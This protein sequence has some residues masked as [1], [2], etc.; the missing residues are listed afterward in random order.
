MA[1]VVIIVKKVVFILNAAKTVPYSTV[2][3]FVSILVGIVI[4]GCSS[5]SMRYIFTFPQGRF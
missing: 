3:D 4:L 2:S 1:V 5:Y